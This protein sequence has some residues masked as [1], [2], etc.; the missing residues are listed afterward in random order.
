MVASLIIMTVLLSMAYVMTGSLQT[1]GCSRQRNAANSVVNS[2]LEEVRALPY[3]TVAAGDDTT[4]DTKYLPGGSAA[5]SNLSGSAAPY[6]YTPTGETFVTNTSSTAVAPIT[7]HVSSVAED[8]TTYTL[9]AYVTNDS[10]ISGAY[11]VTAVAT[12]SGGSCRGVSESVSAQT[13][14]EQPSAITSPC[15]S[16]TTHPF[17]AP[18]AAELYTVVNSGNGYVEIQPA[19]GVSGDAIAG[20]NLSSAELSL[21]NVNCNLQIEQVAAGNCSATSSATSLDLN[22]SSASTSGG[23]TSSCADSS[24]PSNSALTCSSSLVAADLSTLTA[25]GSGNTLTLSP[26]L[27]VDTGS[28][29]DSTAASTNPA[30]YDLTGAAITDSLPCDY[31][32]VSQIA[33]LGATLLMTASSKSLGSAVLASIGPDVAYK[34]AS[35]VS[36][37]ADD[38]LFDTEATSSNDGSYCSSTSGSGCVHTGA[39]RSFGTIGLAALPPQVVTDLFTSKSKTYGCV[40]GYTF[41]IVGYADNLTAE[42]GVSASAPTATQGTNSSSGAYVEYANS[43]GTCTTTKINWGTSPSQISFPTVTE[44]D[45]TVIGTSTPVTVTITPTITL[46]ATAITDTTGCSSPACITAATSTV[47]SPATGTIVYDVTEGSGSS[48]TTLCDIQL[49]FSLGT[50]SAQTSYTAAPSAS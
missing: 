38:Q 33:T 36:Y 49:T 4:D 44:T 28:T 9:Y 25:T 23:A 29:V 19:S 34:P 8:S 11:R 27:S 43:A 7:P 47:P 41:A 1:L 42:A 40:S 39:Q 6:T 18:C 50:M 12:W 2:A 10:A 37:R 26:T 17:P 22:G 45:T 46:N 3:A 30:C 21:P 16:D 35:G 14:V 5:D 20:I 24:D 48:L 32:T 15:L 31:G 13:I